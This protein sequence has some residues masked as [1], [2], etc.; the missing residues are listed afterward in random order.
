MMS[1]SLTGR[2]VET[3]VNDEIVP[4]LEID[5]TKEFANDVLNRFRNPFLRHKLQDIT[6]QYTSK[7]KTRVL[8]IIRKYREKHNRLPRHILFG[9][10]A[11]LYLMKDSKERAL[12]DEYSAILLDFWKSASDI[13]QE[14]LFHFVT[15]VSESQELWGMN[16]NGIPE[17]TVEVSK[18]LKVIIQDGVEK[19]LD[20]LMMSQAKNT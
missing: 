10:A 1:D 3:V 18:C 9:F 19:A 2:F 11:Y 5:G 14:S 13:N 16:L 4:S 20:N 6:F 17:F 15:K 8:P 7:I 12:N